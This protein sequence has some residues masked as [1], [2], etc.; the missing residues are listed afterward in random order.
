[1]DVSMAQGEKGSSEKWLAQGTGHWDPEA[2]LVW[3]L[4]D[5]VKRRGW[6]VWRE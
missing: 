3:G 5:H 2:E 6:V 4:G 1:M